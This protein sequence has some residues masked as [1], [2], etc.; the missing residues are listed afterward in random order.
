MHASINLPARVPNKHQETP[1]VNDPSWGHFNEFLEGVDW[2]VLD[3]NLL[4]KGTPYNAAVRV[5]LDIK[6]L[7]KPL[8]VEALGSK[9]W[10]LSSDWHRFTII[11]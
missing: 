1:R 5:K 7:P 10:D 6:Q 3:R 9:D 8:Q 4:K 11:P 2:K